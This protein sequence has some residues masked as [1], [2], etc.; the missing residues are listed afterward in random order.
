MKLDHNPAVIQVVRYGLPLIILIFYISASWNFSYTPDSTFL[1]VRTAAN[2]IAG[3]TA[4]PIPS[5]RLGAPNPLWVLLLMVAGVVNLD[6]LLA[7][8][9]FSLFF[10]SLAVLLTYLLASELLRDR[11][12]SFCAALAFATSGLLLQVAPT[13]SAVPLALALMLAGLFFMLRNDYLVSAFMLGLGTLICWQVAGVFLLLLFDAWLNATEFRRKVRLVLFCLVIY[14][15]TVVPWFLYVA[16]RAVPPVPWLVGLNDYPGL[17]PA[18]VAAA[19]IPIVLGATAAIG[20]LRHNRVEGLV[21]E[22]HFILILWAGWFLACW[23]LWGKDFLVLAL[24]VI[25]VYAISIVRQV[26]VMNRS[27]T[28]YMQALLLTGSLILLHQLSFNLASKPAMVSTQEATEELVELAYWIKNGVPEEASVSAE[29]PELL[30]YYAGRPVRFWNTEEK[31]TTE[32]LVSE[33]EDVWG[34]AVVHRASL[35]E[36]GELL[37]GA[38]R[39][40]VWRAK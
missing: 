36:G 6:L 20:M 34:F 30:S 17:S 27:V 22:S 39:F 35:P 11:F 31:P 1:S 32:F 9:I 23:A 33:R 13:G 38:G 40:A 37:S 4:D 21:R 16:L 26:E 3:G 15:F 7:A 29:C 19:A 25:L 28:A 18:T 2:V 14:V 8:K 10:S 24:P 12:L 5:Q